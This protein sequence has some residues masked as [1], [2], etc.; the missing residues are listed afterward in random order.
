M[1]HRDSLRQHLDRWVV[2]GRYYDTMTGQFLSVDPAVQQTQQA[3]IYVAD[4]PV[5]RTDP[6]GQDFVGV[7]GGS[8]GFN[9]QPNPAT[10]PCYATYNGGIPSWVDDVLGWVG[11]NIGTIAQVSGSGACVLLTAGWC[12]VGI[13][14]STLTELGDRWVTGRLTVAN[15]T[16]TVLLGVT[17]LAAAGTSMLM[18]KIADEAAISL[19]PALKTVVLKTIN[20]VAAMPYVTVALNKD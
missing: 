3:F 13:G 16:E 17:S 14:L 15:A 9:C 19:S 18:E 20:V 1:V 11:H 4:D 8:A 7:E 2:V 10:G 6:N 12:M 5:H